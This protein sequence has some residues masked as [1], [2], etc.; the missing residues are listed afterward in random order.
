VEFDISAT[1]QVTTP[2]VPIGNPTG[3]FTE[4]FFTDRIRIDRTAP[5]LL[6]ALI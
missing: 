1:D 5:T 3:I 2:V 4:E 6:V